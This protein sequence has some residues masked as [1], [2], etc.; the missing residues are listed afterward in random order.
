[1]VIMYKIPPSMS[2]SLNMAIVSVLHKLG[3]V[4]TSR[5]F[6]F[7]SPFSLRIL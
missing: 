6:L 3:C 2:H 7:M 5:I 4:Y 1:M